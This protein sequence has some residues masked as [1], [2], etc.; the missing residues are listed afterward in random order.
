[1][2]KASGLT[3]PA[4]RSLRRSL[5]NAREIT[6]PLARVGA[7]GAE[8][9]VPAKGDL[10]VASTADAHW[11]LRIDGVPMARSTTYGWANQFT[12][13][14]TGSGRLT[15]DTPL[16]RKLATT[17]QLVLWLLVILLSFKLNLLSSLLK[18]CSTPA[19]TP[20]QPAPTPCKPAPTTCY[21]APKYGC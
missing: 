19:P 2:A 3:L 18:S 20:C 4:S 9:R 15:Y 6:L 11:H 7:V 8:G 1:M 16:A 13:T 5:S 21:T 17:G 12:A 10:L 14:R